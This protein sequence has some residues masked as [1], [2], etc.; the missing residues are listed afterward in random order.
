MKNLVK[1]VCEN[2]HLPY[3]TFSPTFS[4]CPNHGYLEGEHELCPKCK[5]ECEIYTRIVG[6]I[7]PVNQWNKGKQSEF[8]MRKTFKFNEA[9]EK[10]LLS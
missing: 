8:K 7:R 10:C 5:E 9:K 6:Y 1:K 4:V 2:Y 3:F